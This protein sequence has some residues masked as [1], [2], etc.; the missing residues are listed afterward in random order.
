MIGFIGVGNMAGAIING[1]LAGGI[2]DPCDIGVYDKFAEKTDAFPQLVKFDGIASLAK[3]CDIIFLCVKPA[4]VIDALTQMKDTELDTKT[5]VSIA[6]GIATDDIQTVLGRKAAVIR[7]MPNT[8]MLYRKGIAIMSK[9]PKVSEDV[10]VKVREIFGSIASTRLIDE[11]KQN[12]VI[13]LT[14]SSPAYVY[15]L[16]DAMAEASA[17]DGFDKE[18]SIQLIADLLEGVAE[19]L[20][21]S[22]KTP[23]ELIRMVTSPNGTTAEAMAVF[24]KRDFRKIVEEAM[25][26]CTKRAD[27]MTAEMQEKL[28]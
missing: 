25:A 5:I 17:K 1:I 24:E 23:A 9:T 16:A 15:L 20:R 6:A 14:G 2:T 18:D 10:F 11:E 27:E 13:A 7:V 22:G 4:D 8:P 19:M 12:A 28:H 26:A 21:R 3:G